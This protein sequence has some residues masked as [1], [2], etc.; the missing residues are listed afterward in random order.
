MSIVLSSSVGNGG[1][2]SP[3][4]VKLVRDRFVA[5]GFSW[6]SG[7]TTVGP[8]FIKAIRLFQAIK[9]GSDVVNAGSKI[10]GRIDPGG[11]TLKW[12]NASNAPRWMRLT[13][14]DVGL[15]NY[16]VKDTTDTHDYGTQWL[17]DTLRAAGKTYHSA[18]LTWNTK[19][20]PIAVNDASLPQGGDTPSHAGHE[21]G[22]VADLRLPK[23]DGSVGGITTADLR[24]DRD[25]MRAQLQA[26]RAQ[27]LFDRV[28]L[29]DS[30][31]IGEGLCAPLSGH[32]DHVH[33]EIKPPPRA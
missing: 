18:W 10:D 14:Q 13:E 30:T 8:T 12:L 29:N 17:D 27:P 3:S 31:L 20:A 19:A 9:S 23:K 4:D 1:V 22:L 5:L 11:D 15:V 7:H 6:L 16:E 2:N 24:F 33:Y 21:T 25:A 26:L 32:D 28:F